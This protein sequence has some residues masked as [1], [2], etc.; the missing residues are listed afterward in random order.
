MRLY[1]GLCGLLAMAVGTEASAQTIQLPSVHVFSADTT[2]IAPDSGQSW[3][4]G[5]KRASSGANRFRGV[6]PQRAA[7]T[8][9][10][11]RANLAPSRPTA[12][13]EI[14]LGASDPGLKSVAEI[15]RQRA[16]QA[17]AQARETLAWLDKARQARS[18]G[19]TSTAAL[20]YRT[21]ARQANGDLK[22]QIDAE[23]RQIKP[24]T[25]VAKSGQTAH[26]GK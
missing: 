6:P 24:S 19:K 17:A 9:Q 26:A 7:G 22:H 2:V 20:Y 18:A 5:E 4:A 14:V 15:Q 23:M 10:A 1:I 11:R 8:E 12:N 13:A 16:Q 3:V 21:A 25:P